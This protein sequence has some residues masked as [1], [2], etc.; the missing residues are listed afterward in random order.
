MRERECSPPYLT[1]QHDSGSCLF[2]KGCY[3]HKGLREGRTHVEIPTA[4]TDLAPRVQEERHHRDG[5]TASAPFAE[6]H[7]RSDLENTSFSMGIYFL[8][9]L[10]R[11][12]ETKEQAYWCDT[13]PFLLHLCHQLSRGQ[14]RCC[15]QSLRVHT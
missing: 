4:N 15:L 1:Q 5:S 14:Q 6:D 8:S 2:C 12:H 7:K 3:S 13:A 11:N 10:N 9:H